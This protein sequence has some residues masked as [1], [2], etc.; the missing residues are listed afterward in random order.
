MERRYPF[1]FKLSKGGFTTYDCYLYYVPDLPYMKPQ[2]TIELGFCSNGTSFIK[3][4]REAI[5]E[6]IPARVFCEGY[7]SVLVEVVYKAWTGNEFNG[8][9]VKCCDLILLSTKKTDFFVPY[10]K[11]GGSGNCTKYRL[12]DPKEVEH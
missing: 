4:F 3:K 2:F 10:T 6:T 11:I 12:P 7:N 8:Y 1:Q 5:K 9:S